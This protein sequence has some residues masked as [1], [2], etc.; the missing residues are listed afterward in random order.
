MP[1]AEPREACARRVP[2]PTNERAQIKTFPQ[3]T[4]CKGRC[5]RSRIRTG[6]ACRPTRFKLVVSAFHHPGTGSW[7]A[8]LATALPWT[9]NEPIRGA[10][11]DNGLP[12][13]GCLILLATDAASAARAPLQR[14]SRAPAPPPGM[15]ES[16]CPATGRHQGVLSSSGM[17]RASPV[18]PQTP[19]ETGSGVD[20]GGRFRTD[21]GGVPVKPL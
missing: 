17:T 6:T 5:A 3:L 19:S 8:R 10:R 12:T 21:D 2:K 16:R 7:T 1:Y 4:R 14:G 11:S 18:P 15:T 20:A 9:L 13:P